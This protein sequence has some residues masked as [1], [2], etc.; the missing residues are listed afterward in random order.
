[1]LTRTGKKMNLH[2]F[3]TSLCHTLPKGVASIE[4]III[5]G[6]QIIVRYT[7]EQEPDEQSLSLINNSR[8]IAVNSLD[9][10][11]LYDGKLMEHQD[12]I[13]QI[14]TA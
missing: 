9:M 14:K 3:I 13:Y 4:D 8:V 7:T 10:L 2:R 6:N 5:K 1:M 12:T 11:R